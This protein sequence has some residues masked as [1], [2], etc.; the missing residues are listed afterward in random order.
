M[1]FGMNRGKSGA[2]RDRTDDLLY[3]IQAL[4]QLS[5]GPIVAIIPRGIELSS[6]EDHGLIHEGSRA[7]AGS[8]PDGARS[9]ARVSSR[10]AEKASLLCMPTNLFTTSPFLI[11][12]TVGIDWIKKCM[13]V[14][15]LLSTSILP[16][17]TRP[18]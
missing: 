17:L 10:A 12:I 11:R 4:S 3:A 8:Q 18:A 1:I 16:T 5:Y 13:A 15:L 14:S 2:D 9:Q 6:R 7:P